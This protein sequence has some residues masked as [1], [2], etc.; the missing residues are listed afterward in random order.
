[1]RNCVNPPRADEDPKIA[2]SVARLVLV[3][4]KTSLEVCVHIETRAV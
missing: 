1:M 2:R 4:I 3:S